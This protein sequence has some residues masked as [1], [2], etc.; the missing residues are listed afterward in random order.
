MESNNKY[1]FEHKTG[2]TSWYHVNEPNKKGETMQFSI[3]ECEDPK[4]KNSLPK[5]WKKHGYMDRVLK[6]YLSIH[7]YVTDTNGDCWGRYNPQL[8]QR[9]NHEINFEWMFE[10]TEENKQKL[11][12]EVIRRFEEAA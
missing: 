12:N 10:N 2:S 9:N 3:S 5:L 4:F 6:T 7:T 1:T 8:K 11:I